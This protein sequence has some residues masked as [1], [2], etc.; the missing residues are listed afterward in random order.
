MAS[1]GA[2]PLVHDFLVNGSFV[3]ETHDDHRMQV[4]RKDVK[5]KGKAID[6]TPMADAKAAMDAV[7]D[8]RIHDITN[9]KLSPPPIIT[10]R[11]IFS[12]LD[13]P[14]PAA[15]Q[16]TP[17]SEPHPKKKNVEREPTVIIESSPEPEKYMFGMPNH[18][19]GGSSYIP[20]PSSIATPSR[21][22]LGFPAF[23]D[24]SRQGSVVSLLDG[25][26]SGTFDFGAS[27]ARRR[28]PTA[29]LDDT[30]VPSSRS[31]SPMKAPLQRST[32]R[33]SLSPMK[34]DHEATKALQESNHQLAG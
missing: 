4:D 29:V 6:D 8:N 30:R 20:H 26:G 17:P 16:Q 3:P 34:V 28:A 18:T 27:L 2:I 21:S 5:G 7:D 12:C 22:S 23:A 14:L 13:D 11:P 33:S 25:D 9:S 15:P 32:S 1:S 10:R 24:P 31:P 19:L